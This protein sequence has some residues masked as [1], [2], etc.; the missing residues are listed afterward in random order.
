MTMADETE[1]T[2]EAADTC[3]SHDEILTALKDRS[4]WEN[5][6]TTWYKMRHDGLR[7]QNKPWANAADMHFP[8]ADMIIEK[9][10]PYYIGQIFA[11]DNVASFVGLSSETTAAAV[12][13]IAETGPTAEVFANPRHEYTQRLL[14]SIPGKNWTPPRFENA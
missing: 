11:T 1:K 14:A 5:R 4:T 2:H 9:L 6:Q 7:R 10:K 8:L 12:G 3:P 13:E